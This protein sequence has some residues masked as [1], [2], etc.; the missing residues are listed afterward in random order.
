MQGQLAA[1]VLRSTPWVG[2]Y[3]VAAGSSG[4]CQRDTGLRCAGHAHCAGAAMYRGRGPSSGVGAWANTPGASTGT[5]AAHQHRQH[6]QHSCRAHLH[7]HPAIAS[8]S[9]WHEQHTLCEVSAAPNCLGGNEWSCGCAGSGCG[10]SGLLGRGWEDLWHILLRH[11]GAV[12]VKAPHLVQRR[13]PEELQRY[14]ETDQ[15]SM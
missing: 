7:S 8:Q 3:C 4:G 6:L 9:Q 11:V 15:R 1:C 10:H 13:I 5:E 12:V 2:L 14:F